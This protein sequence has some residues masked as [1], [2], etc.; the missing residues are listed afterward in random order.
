MHEVLHYVVDKG[1]KKERKK[2]NMMRLKNKKGKSEN[3]CLT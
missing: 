1:R 2:C 3:W